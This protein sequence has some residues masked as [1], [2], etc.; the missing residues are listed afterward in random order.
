MLKAGFKMTGLDVEGFQAFTTTPGVGAGAGG[1]AATATT[2]KERLTVLV[3]LPRLLRT[4]PVNAP[5]AL[6]SFH[7]PVC[8]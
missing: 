5:C 8:S 6:C 3:D 7:L 1:N 2:G 4:P